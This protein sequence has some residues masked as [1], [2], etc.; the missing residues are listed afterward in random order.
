MARVDK[1]RFPKPPLPL[2]GPWPDGPWFLLVAAALAAPVAVLA[3]GGDLHVALLASLVCL[4]TPAGA[5]EAML[6]LARL[7]LATNPPER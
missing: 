2:V 3:Q 1:P 5:I 4:A 6:G 7:A